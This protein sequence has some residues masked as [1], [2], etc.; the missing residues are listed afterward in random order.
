MQD[1]TLEE[2]VTETGCKIGQIR[3]WIRQGTLVRSPE[4]P[5]RVTRASVETLKKHY[6]LPPKQF[7]PLTGTYSVRWGRRTLEGA[8]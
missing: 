8:H 5:D 3:R 1:P 4:G 7:S 2:V 6:S